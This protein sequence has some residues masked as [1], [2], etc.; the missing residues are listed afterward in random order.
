MIVIDN[1]IWEFEKD[2]VWGMVTVAEAYAYPTP[3]PFF[4]CLLLFLSRATHTSYNT[5]CKGITKHTPRAFF[6]E[7]KTNLLKIRFEY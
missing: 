1:L 5:K 2:S 6:I 7:W 4:L 3:H